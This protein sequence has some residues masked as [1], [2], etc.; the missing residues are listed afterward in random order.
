MADRTLMIIKPDAVSRNA[1]GGILKLVE[2]K[3][4]KIVALQMMHLTRAQAAQFYAVHQERPFFNDLLD[5]MTSG[6]AVP[7]VLEKDKAV[8]SLREIVGATNPAEAAEG[9]IRKA[10]GSNVQENAVHASDSPENAAIEV[11][12]FFGP[13][14]LA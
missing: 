7:L 6:P 11:A 13:Q 10:F 12:F 4:F 9:T 8:P 2:E 3:G 14:A 5:F 1:I